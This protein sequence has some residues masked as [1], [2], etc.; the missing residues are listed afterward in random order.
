[1]SREVSSGE[2]WIPL[3][4]KLFFVYTPCRKLIQSVKNMYS[5]GLLEEKRKMMPWR[6]ILFVP[7][8]VKALSVQGLVILCLQAAIMAFHG[9]S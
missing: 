7:S 5:A 1:M 2:L 8:I 3:P 6:W 4:S 9:G